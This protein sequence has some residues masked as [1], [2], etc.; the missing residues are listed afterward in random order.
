MCVLLREAFRWCCRFCQHSVETGTAT[1]PVQEII[2]APALQIPVIKCP[3]ERRSSIT[4]HRKRLTQLASKEGR[5]TVGEMIESDIDE[6]LDDDDD[7]DDDKRG[8]GR[9]H[10]TYDVRCQKYV[11]SAAVAVNVVGRA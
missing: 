5:H 2:I 4:L 10:F 11:S 8:E 3:P 9:V 1:E 6:E 7:H